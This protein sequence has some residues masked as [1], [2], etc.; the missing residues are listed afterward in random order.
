MTGLKASTLFRA[1]DKASDCFWYFVSK[2]GTGYNVAYI[3][4]FQRQAKVFRDKLTEKLEANEKELSV[5]K[6]ELHDAQLEYQG[7]VDKYYHERG[8]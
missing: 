4:E 7:I 8:L 6:R 2:K 5:M 1:Y 3:K